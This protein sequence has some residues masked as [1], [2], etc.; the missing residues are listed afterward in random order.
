MLSYIV[1]KDVDPRQNAVRLPLG[2]PRSHR[3]RRQGSVLAY[4][5][6]NHG[7]YFMY[8]RAANAA[9]RLEM[10]YRSM[11]K[12]YDW[13]LEKFRLSRKA[14]DK[15]NKKRTI[16][17]FFRFVKNPVAYISWKTQMWLTPLPKLLAVAGIVYMVG[18]INYWKDISNEY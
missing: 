16:K 5:L 9:E 2:A 4:A 18:L 17:N 7:Q 8:D 10:T 14:N 1:S 15:G 13:E 6:S 3:R 12:Q 11:G